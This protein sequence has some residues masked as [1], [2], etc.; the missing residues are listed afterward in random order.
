VLCA[1]DAELLTPRPQDAD[2]LLGTSM[3]DVMKAQC[4]VW[5]HGTRPTDFHAPLKTDKPVLILEGE[6]D[7]VTPP[8]YG[9]QVL[10]GLGNGRLLILKGQGHSVM[11]RG[12][13]P[14]LVEEF[15]NKL[16][17]NA[18]DAKCLDALGPTPAFIDFN[19]AAP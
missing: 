17:P 3:I 8:R 5:P 16:L 7:P 13:L 18:L 19:G 14:K 1:E 4:E 12:C 9:A 10:K 6:F 2:T 11:G 15:M